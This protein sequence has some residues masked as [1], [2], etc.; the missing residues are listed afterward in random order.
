[1]HYSALLLLPALLFP[2][3][4]SDKTPQPVAMPADLVDDSYAIYSQMVGGES[5]DGDRWVAIS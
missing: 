1:M 4:Q 2:T 5:P 3:A